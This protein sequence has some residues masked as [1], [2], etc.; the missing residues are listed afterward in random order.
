[1]TDLVKVKDL[2]KGELFKRKAGAAAVYV[3]GDYVRDTGLNK[4]SCIDYDDI[5][6]E[7]FLKGD[8][9]VTVNLD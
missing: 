9:L 5:C 3:R 7:I 8:T 1:M 4:Y 2:K 6:R